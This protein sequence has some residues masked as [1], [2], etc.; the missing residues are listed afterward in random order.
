MYHAKLDKKTAIIIDEAARAEIMQLLKYRHGALREWSLHCIAK[1]VPAYRRELSVV[2]KP[3]EEK[4]PLP[5][6]E[7]VLGKV[8]FREIHLQVYGLKDDFYEPHDLWCVVCTGRLRLD[9][10]SGKTSLR[11]LDATTRIA[12][13]LVISGKSGAQLAVELKV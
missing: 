8:S 5:S 7:K 6:P 13:D 11:V 4:P 12:I 9:L 2:A 1:K 3:A 10:T